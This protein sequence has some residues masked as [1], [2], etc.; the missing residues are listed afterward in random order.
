MG[1]FLCRVFA[2]IVLVGAAVNFSVVLKNSP[3]FN[4]DER[5]R[6]VVG[7]WRVPNVASHYDKAEYLQELAYGYLYEL[8]LTYDPKTEEMVLIDPEEMNARTAKAMELLDQVIQLDP[9]NAS[10]WA[11]L[12]QAHSR[13]NEMGAMRESLSRSWALAPNNLQLAPLRLSLVMMIEQD[14]TGVPLLAEEIEAVRRDARVLHTTSPRYLAR[15]AER[16][17][18]IKSLVVELEAITTSS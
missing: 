11:Y 7:G 4:G 13:T 17:E 2:V 6:S 10:A 8:G 12:A 1:R 15:L 3:A 18:T 14:H 9:S 16:S 5:Q